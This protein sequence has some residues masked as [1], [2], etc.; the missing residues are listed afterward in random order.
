MGEMR[1]GGC[2][3]DEVEIFSTPVCNHGGQVC[4][5]SQRPQSPT[6]NTST[7]G[8]QGYF[9]IRWGGE[10]GEEGQDRRRRTGDEVIGER[11][12]EGLREMVKEG[13]RGCMKGK[14]SNA[15]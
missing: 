11:K 12:D 7:T 6:P 14:G 3:G 1:G 15:G 9:Y 5:V 2:W 8:Q 13:K 4:W 10:G